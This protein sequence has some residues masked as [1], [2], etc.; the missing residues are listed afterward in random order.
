MFRSPTSTEKLSCVEISPY[1]S[2]NVVSYIFFLSR[3]HHHPQTNTYNF[4]AVCAF[5]STG[6]IL[7]AFITSPLTLSF[8]LIKSFCAFAFPAT[9]CPKSFSLSTNVTLGF[10]PDGAA[11]FPTVPVSL[12]SMCHFSTAPDA[13]FSSKA[14]T[15][16]PFLTA[17]F[18]SASL[19]ERD[20][21]I[22]SNA[23]E[24]GKSA[25][26]KHS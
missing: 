20:V 16:P 14:K 22:T 25:T 19:E 10:F 1:G 18:R 24:E 7:V 13:F 12:R 21:E 15:L 17:S 5:L 8:P 6:S 3:L 9:S 2:L 23:A 4:A 11:P 26:Q